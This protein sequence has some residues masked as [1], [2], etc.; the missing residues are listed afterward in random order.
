VAV[1]E[2]EDPQ[3]AKEFLAN[4]HLGFAV[5]DSNGKAGKAYG[6]V[7]LPV[8]IFINRAGIVSTYRLGEMNPAEMESAIQAILRQS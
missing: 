6:A 5:V 1:D 4:Y 3:K 7:G 8:H 2:L